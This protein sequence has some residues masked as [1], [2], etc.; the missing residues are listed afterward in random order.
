MRQFYVNAGALRRKITAKDA[1]DAATI[2]IR[3]ALNILGDRALLL[4]SRII[5][6]EAGYRDSVNDI[7]EYDLPNT[8]P[9]PISA[10]F[11]VSELCR[12]K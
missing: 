9:I 7:R 12:G 11:I 6:H 5:V 1:I 3:D 10:E 2:V 4:T 8:F